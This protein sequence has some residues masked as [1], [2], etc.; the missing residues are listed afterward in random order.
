MMA[1]SRRGRTSTSCGGSKVPVSG[2]SHEA[3][4]WARERPCTT[5]P[6]LDRPAASAVCSGREG[7]R[8]ERHDQRRVGQLLDP[9]TLPRVLR[10][11]SRD[12]RALDDVDL[13][14]DCPFDEAL[15]EYSPEYR[16]LHVSAPPPGEGAWGP[17]IDAGVEVGRIPVASVRL[18]ESRRRF[19]DRSSVEAVLAALQ[20]KL[21]TGGAAR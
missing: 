12:S 18:D 3:T 13:L 7:K 1:A 2:L 21:R 19:I 16:I 8:G 17:S 6:A 14:L 11:A 15:D 10:R 9:D 5:V 20:L 4:G